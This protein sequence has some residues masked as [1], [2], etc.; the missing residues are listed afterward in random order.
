MYKFATQEAGISD[1][2]DPILLKLYK[3]GVFRHDPIFFRSKGKWTRT[4]PRSKKKLTIKR[5]TTRKSKQ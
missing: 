3:H 1:P 5:T 4:F 2:D